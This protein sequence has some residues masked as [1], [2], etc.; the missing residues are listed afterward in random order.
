MKMQ[1]DAVSYGAL[2]RWEAQQR[3]KLEYAGHDL[4]TPVTAV[5]AER[6]PRLSP[7]TPPA[8]SGPAFE[9]TGWHALYRNY[10]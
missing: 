7:N 9:A 5:T 4:T 10:T 3:S 1:A 8:G 2:G 6:T